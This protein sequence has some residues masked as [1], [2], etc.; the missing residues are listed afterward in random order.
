MTMARSFLRF[1]PDSMTKQDFL[2][3]CWLGLICASCVLGTTFLWTDGL[4]AEAGATSWVQFLGRFHPLTLHLPIGLFSGLCLLEAVY[5]F[6]RNPGIR[7]AADL[8]LSLTVLSAIVAACLGLFL[9]ANGDYT[10]PTADRHKWLGLGFAVGTILLAAAQLQRD[11]AAG[12]AYLPLLVVLLAVM[13]LAGHFG[14]SLTHGS[15]YLTEYAPAWLKQHLEAQ[16]EEPEQQAAAVVEE[17][18]FYRHTIDPILQQ[19]CIK[20]HGPDKQ[21]SD[22]RVDSYEYLLLAGKNEETP[23]VPGEPHNSYLV[24]LLWLHESHDMAM[25]PEGKPRPSADEIL[26][27]THWV[28]NGARGPAESAVEKQA[29]EAHEQ[30]Q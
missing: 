8:L 4:S 6:K 5:F 30:A 29:R 13:S 11:R 27:I 21:K 23:I 7:L 14:G 16:P 28:A 19:Y 17:D 26:T 2:I 12:K 15:S 3:P 25:P 1:S 22:Y 10:G 9:F 18:D 20:C 24:Q